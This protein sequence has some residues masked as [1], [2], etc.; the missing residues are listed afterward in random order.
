MNNIITIGLS[1]SFVLV[2][3]FLSVYAENYVNEEYGTS[4]Q[5]DK[6]FKILESNSTY[7][8]MIPEHKANDSKEI[9][10]EYI[11]DPLPKY[12]SVYADYESGEYSIVDTST[13]VTRL[14]TKVDHEILSDRPM[15]NDFYIIKNSPEPNIHIF[16]FHTYGDDGSKHTFVLKVLADGY[17]DAKIYVDPVVKTIKSFKIINNS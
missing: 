8:K 13:N 6:V 15:L 14:D 9:I 1:A 5:H 11:V 3:L 17:T 12:N 10:F 7:V 2:S 16:S 4:F